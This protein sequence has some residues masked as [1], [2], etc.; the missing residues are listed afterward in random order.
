[1]NLQLHHVISDIT[2]VSGV[3]IL[4]AIL[5]GER[6]PLKLASLRDHRIKATEETVAKSLVG[7][8]RPEHLFTLRQSLDA[9]RY[10]RKLIAECDDEVQRHLVQFASKAD[11]KQNPL[12][13]P[14]KVSSSKVYSS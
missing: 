3:T 1:M 2:G 9:W 8:Y 14:R 4:D 6:D 7:D 13:R 10:H 11:P 12:P 5:N